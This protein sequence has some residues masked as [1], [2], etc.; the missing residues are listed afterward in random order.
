MTDD[1]GCATCINWHRSDAIPSFNGEAGGECHRYAPRPSL[2]GPENSSVVCWPLTRE[3]EVCGEWY[4]GR[5]RGLVA[6]EV[7]RFDQA[8][9]TTEM[10]VAEDD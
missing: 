10:P 2:G 5:K 1:R 7:P 6:D 4:F 3:S 9:P 8:R